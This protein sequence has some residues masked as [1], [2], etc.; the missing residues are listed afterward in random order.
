MSNRPDSA[1][2]RS[3][4]VAERYGNDG[5][6]SNPDLTDSSAYMRNRNSNANSNTKVGIVKG[7]G[8]AGLLASVGRGIR[9]KFFENHKLCMLFYYLC[10][11]NHV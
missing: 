10:E 6:R 1:Q 9:C 4:W 2:S 5:I 7:A 8:P 3:A 11:I